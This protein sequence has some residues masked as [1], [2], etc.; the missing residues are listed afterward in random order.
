M[1]TLPCCLL[2]SNMT[3]NHEITMSNAILAVVPLGNQWP[4]LDPFLFCAH[5]NDRYPRGDGNS[6]PV[7]GTAGRAI[8]SDFSGKDGWSMYHGQRVPGFPAHPHRG[9]ETITIARK[10]FIDHADS[11]GAHAR[12][13]EGDVQWMTAGEGVVHSEMFP[14]L[15]TDEEN[16]AELFQIWLNLPAASR[17]ADAY[18]TMFWADQIPIVESEGVQV[19]VV[20]GRLGDAKA[21]SPP[22][23][24]WASDD[25][26]EVTVLTLELAPSAEFSL[27]T[28]GAGS[29]RILYFFDGD[30]MEIAGADFD[31]GTGIQLVPDVEVVLKNTGEKPA[32]LLLLAA[33]PIGEPVVHHGPFVMS[34]PAEIRQT[35]SDYQRT[36]FGGWP[37]PTNDPVHGD[38]G[39]FAVHADG[40]RDEPQ[41]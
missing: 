9:F 24:S 11:M 7:G 1:H 15:D 5:H 25:S 14:L 39:R 3:S 28:G 8:G 12:F 18:F 37:W 2:S 13:G 16:H 19:S 26:A 35:I 38:S 36:R 17:R 4:T 23:N 29:S 27:P 32:E 21:L 31:A 10:G 34:T 20:A 41:T 22:P 40:R 6:A 30:K 33:K